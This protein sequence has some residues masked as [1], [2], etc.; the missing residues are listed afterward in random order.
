MAV[1]LI[2]K[3]LPY[4]CDLDQCYTLEK[5][6]PLNDLQ[7]MYIQVSSKEER[8]TPNPFTVTLE[9][10]WSLTLGYFSLTSC[11]CRSGSWTVGCMYPGSDQKL[12]MLKR[13]QDS[14]AKWER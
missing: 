4:S 2:S 11:V 8:K 12:A 9:G 10:V 6:Y 13:L 14:E 5:L 1:E 7:Q 3:L